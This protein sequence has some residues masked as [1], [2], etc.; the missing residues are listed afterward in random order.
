MTLTDETKLAIAER[1]ARASRTN[2]GDAYA[3]LCAPDAMT[4]HNFDDAEV[5][6]EQTVRT[7][8]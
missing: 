4:W 5:G 6:T 1:F 3:A 8:R 7:V 2:D